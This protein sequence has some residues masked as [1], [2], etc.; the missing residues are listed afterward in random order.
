MYIFK[1]IYSAY[2]TED[3]G[4][5]VQTLFALMAHSASRSYNF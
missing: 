1:T 5:M 3:R 4:P 2:P